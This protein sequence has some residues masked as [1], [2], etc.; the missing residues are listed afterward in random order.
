MCKCCRGGLEKARSAACQPP[1]CV[2]RT[3]L[4]SGTVRRRGPRDTTLVGR[5]S[6]PAMMM[7]FRSRQRTAPRS[8][9]DGFSGP[10]GAASLKGHRRGHPVSG[11]CRAPASRVS[12]SDR[13][14]SFDACQKM[15]P[16]CHDNGCCS[17]DR[18]AREYV[19]LRPQR[20]QCERRAC[21]VLRG[22]H[23]HGCSS[24]CV[25]EHARPVGVVH[26]HRGEG[27]IS[28]KTLNIS[29]ASITGLEP[30]NPV[31]PEPTNRQAPAGSAC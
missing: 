12:A 28:D 14:E 13:S 7:R 15:G 1:F 29:N 8:S 27:T 16:G 9:Y 24:G 17:T 31:S 20:S 6:T 30:L 26:H 3:N 10:P 23:Q 18:G 4:L 21:R 22:R 2:R 11:R 5:S 19:R 25:A